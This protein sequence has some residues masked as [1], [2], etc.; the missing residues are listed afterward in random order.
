M[1]NKLHPANRA[2]DA[3]MSRQ[4]GSGIEWWFDAP[5]KE[6]LLC[7]LC[8]HGRIREA[9]DI[10][11]KW[12]NCSYCKDWTNLSPVQPDYFVRLFS[13]KMKEE[14]DKGALVLFVEDLS[15]FLEI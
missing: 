14:Y 2:H 15:T 4:D 11:Y 1:N 5:V 10:Y 13:K 9:G 3:P 12:F 7:P 8:F 6:G